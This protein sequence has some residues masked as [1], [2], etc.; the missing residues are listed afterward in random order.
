[1]LTDFY[2]K[3]LKNE[4]GLVDLIRIVIMCNRVISEAK[5]IRKC[6]IGESKV[7]YGFTGGIRTHQHQTVP[8]RFK[9][10][11]GAPKCI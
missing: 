7:K 4:Y 6:V 5:N 11:K 10:V 8:K 9:L 3:I 1:M 2:E